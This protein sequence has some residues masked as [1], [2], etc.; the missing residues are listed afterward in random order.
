MY[1]KNDR[2]QNLFLPCTQKN[3]HKTILLRHMLSPFHQCLMMHEI[4]LRHLLQRVQGQ[5]NLYSA[6][7]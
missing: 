4:Q 1:Y 2:T 5:H 3:L 6:S 7:L